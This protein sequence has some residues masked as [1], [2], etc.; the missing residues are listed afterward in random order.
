[1]RSA[2]K[3]GY[4][5][6][7]YLFSYRLSVEIGSEYCNKYV[8]YKGV[9]KTQTVSHSRY[10]KAARRQARETQHAGLKGCLIQWLTYIGNE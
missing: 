4:A 8:V 7:S 9:S 1:V 2:M 6:S 10:E 5:G 3:F